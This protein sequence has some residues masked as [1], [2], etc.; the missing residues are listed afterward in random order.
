M[1]KATTPDGGV[2]LWLSANNTYDWA[3]RAGAAWPC[4]FL[5]DKPLFAEF[6]SQGDLIDLAINYGQGDQDC[7][8]DEFNA[9]TDDFLRKG[10]LNHAH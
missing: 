10:N 3:N 2:K 8:G 5:A 9:I 6:D 1:R 7:P 4:S